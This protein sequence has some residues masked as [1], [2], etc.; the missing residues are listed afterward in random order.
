MM[1]M[2]DYP[3]EF[4]PDA[5][6]TCEGRCCNGE[7][8][9]IW[10]GKK[11]ITSISG[12]LNLSPEDFV[13]QYLRKK[14]YRFTLIE[15]KQNDNYA[16]VFYAKDKNACN[17]YPVRPEQCRTFPF[18]PYFKTHPSDACEECPGVLEL[19][20]NEDPASSI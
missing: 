7:S 15:L 17:V 9:N 1:R 3:F 2:K 14:G 19:E 6:K 8:G 16:C 20:E 4:N 5:C 12:Y 18:W 11:E 10:V 13:D